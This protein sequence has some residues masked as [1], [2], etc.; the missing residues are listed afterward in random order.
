MSVIAWFQQLTSALR[1][2]RAILSDSAA[3]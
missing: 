3:W 2:R 1:T